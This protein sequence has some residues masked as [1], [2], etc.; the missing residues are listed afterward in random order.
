MKGQ[1][2]HIALIGGR[3][4]AGEVFP[5]ELC[6]EI[7]K[8]LNEQM[9]EDGRLGLGGIGAVFPVEGKCGVSIGVTYPESH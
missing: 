1:H 9:K 7:V 5:E 6:K 2:R 3:A 4:K 8:G